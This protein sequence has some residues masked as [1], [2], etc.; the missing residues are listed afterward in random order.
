MTEHITAY[1]SVIPAPGALQ[2]VSV[3]FESQVRQIMVSNG[4][5]VPK[6]NDLLEI[7]PSPD[8]RLQLEQAHQDLETGQA[9]PSI[10][11]AAVRLKTGHQRSGP[12]GQAKLYDRRSCGWRV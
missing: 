8:T 11:G 7:K 6:G 9:E 1:G 10:C 5:K 2:T 3:P 4:Q 12:P